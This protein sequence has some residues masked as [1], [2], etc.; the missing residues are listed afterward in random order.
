MYAGSM[1]SLPPNARFQPHLEAG[2]QRTLEAVACTPLVMIE[3]SPSAYR[4]GMLALG[5]ALTHE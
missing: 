2:A 4:G 5:K 3:A 1:I